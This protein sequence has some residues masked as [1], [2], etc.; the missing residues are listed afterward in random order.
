MTTE[1][2]ILDNSQ[3]KALDQLNQLKKSLSK[4]SAEFSFL[5][6][7]QKNQNSSSSIYIY[8][9]VGRGKSMLMA[10]FFN[11]LEIEDKIYLHFNSFM[12]KIHRELHK[13]RKNLHRNYDDII[14]IATKNIIGNVRILC[15]DE[16]QVEDVTDA[17]I[18]RKIFSYIFAHQILV[19]FTS[20]SHP[21]N[22]YKN[23]LQRDSFIKFIDEILLK[24]CQVIN[25][26]NGIDYRRQYL[27][28]VK[29]HYFFPINAKNKNEINEIFSK[30]TE[31][32]DPEPIEIKI[33][34]RKLLIKNCYKNVARFDFKELFNEN[35]GVADYQAICK[36]F[37]IIF[38][39]NIPQLTKEDVNEAR[40]LILFIDEI[41]ENKVALLI[42]A[43]V[44][45][46]EI[47]S[48][49]IG[50]E[51]FKRASSRLNEIISD[52]YWQR[53]KYILQ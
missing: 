24:N 46:D 12:Q 25:L 10:K 35:F 13:L 44:K 53:S 7:F 31:G 1:E 8:G 37:D 9:Q 11:S 18:L 20:N 32:S 22:L 40:R 42:L 50:F 3:V 4:S 43:Q 39:L 36:K 47:Y 38:L 26:D 21:K 23:G 30:I 2:P 49:G 5:K 34:G 19:V 28:L 17:L 15:F 27:Q 6:I 52:S 33:L 45:F 29:K 14:E 16:F 48:D 51:S 41:Y